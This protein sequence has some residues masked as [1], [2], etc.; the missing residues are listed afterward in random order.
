MSGHQIMLRS[1]DRLTIGSSR[2]ADLTITDRGCSRIH[3]T[4]DQTDGRWV[5]HDMGSE[6]GTFVDGEQVFNAPID[7]YLRLTMG[8]DG[9]VVK[10]MVHEHAPG[11]DVHVA[12][13]ADE[14]TARVRSRLE[15][16]H[17]VTH[18]RW[19]VVAIAAAV[20]VLIVIGAVLV[21]TLGGDDD[22]E[23]T[24]VAG[25][26]ETLASTTIVAAP[27]PTVSPESTVSPEPTTVVATTTTINPDLTERQLAVP[28]DSRARLFALER[29]GP[30][31][32]VAFVREDYGW[33]LDGDDDCQGTRDEVLIAES[34]APVV[35]ETDA[36]CTVIEGSWVDPYTGVP[37][38]SAEDVLVQPVVALR[39][40]HESGGWAWT[41]D[42][43]RAFVND[44]GHPATLTV[45]GDTP[46]LGKGQKAPDGWRP[47]N[48]AYWCTYAVDWIDV[49][50]RWGLTVTDPER[51]ALAEMLESCRGTSLPSDARAGADNT[52]LDVPTS[53]APPTT[54]L[55]DTAAPDTADQEPLGFGEPPSSLAGECNPNYG[56][57]VPIASDVDCA[58]SNE[59]GPKFVSGPVV[60]L[61]RDVYDL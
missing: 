51:A 16:D 2:Q 37:Y 21:L 15:H 54:D 28:A 43:K 58:G 59:D 48:P 46:N 3:L 20:I 42:A 11:E 12:D 47:A 1:G 38:T 57:C 44:V 23:N 6:Q 40:V 10:L 30:L 52:T 61:G 27:E 7:D 4:I 19:T 35:F 60:V 22:D 24:E 14:L 56:G 31:T 45:V 39:N 26:V 53:T 34:R 29:T 25:T 32:P 55:P 41:P 13:T 36:R 18:R 49:K 5:A 8:A 50:H 33:F 17:E 9:T